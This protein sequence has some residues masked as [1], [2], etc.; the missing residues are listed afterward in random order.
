MARSFTSG[1]LLRG[2]IARGLQAT[3]FM[4]GNSPLPQKKVE[5]SVRIL[6]S[7][8]L[9]S[10]L[11]EIF[12]ETALHASLV[13]TAP[14]DDGL[15]FTS[16]TSTLEDGDMESNPDV[17]LDGNA[18]IGY[19]VQD[20]GIFRYNVGQIRNIIVLG[21][22]GS[23]NGRIVLLVKRYLPSS[24]DWDSKYG[25]PVLGIQTV[26]D[27]VARESDIVALPEVIGHVA[28]IPLDHDQSNDRGWITIQLCKDVT[29]RL[30]LLP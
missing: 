12:G 19:L 21:H 13:P 23:S 3:S 25:H 29:R 2:L 15:Q 17:R 9:H 5:R 26:R 30:R 8:E 11:T 24:I 16:L 14:A 22:Q 27:K 6:L 7:A 1:S 10:R 28:M 4:P 20:N 18:L